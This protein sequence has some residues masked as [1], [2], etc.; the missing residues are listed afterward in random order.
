MSTINNALSGALAAQAGLNTTSQNI[1]NVMTEG[2]T[3][4]GV[5]LSSIQPAKSGPLAAGGGVAVSSLLRFS[6]GYKSVQMWNAASNLGRYTVSQPYLT[7]L[8]QVMGDDTSGLNAGVDAFFAALNAASVEP[9]SSPLRQQVIT[10]ADALA[11]RFN[12]LTQVMSSQRLAIQQQRST[13]VAQINTLTTDIA[14]LNKQIAA[15]QA[16]G[17]NASGLIDERDR[18]I[19]SLASMVSVQVVDQADGSRSISFKS[20]QPLVVGGLA[21]TVSAEGN[22]DGSQTL[23]VVFGKENYTLTGSSLGGQLG[24]LDDVEQNVLLPMMQSIT[25]MASQMA[26]KVN[27][28]LMAGYAQDGTQG[29][30]LF[31]FDATSAVGMLKVNASIVA[32]DLGFSSDATLPGDSGNLLKVID[33]KGQ[34]L[35]LGSL[36]DVSLGDAVTQLVGRLGMASQQ[37]QASLD[38]AQTVRDQTEE[39][40]KSTSGVNSDEEAINLI[41]YQ[42]MYQSNLKVIAVANELFDATLAMMG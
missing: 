31:E 13:A 22:T 24:G 12:S 27:T 21:A 30:A 2:Y 28:Q 23:K 15:T 37:N 33:I 39:S 14:A 1:A 29:V 10:A 40:W 7:Q 20:G 4:Q 36:G 17:V 25:D 3:R 18:K 16:T 19:D 26:S 35:T 34:T 42:Q 11:Q 8:E 9:T 32:Q 6:D 5:L 38:T 41:Q